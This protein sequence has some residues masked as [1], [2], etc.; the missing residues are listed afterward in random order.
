MEKDTRLGNPNR[1]MVRE[2][3]TVEAIIGLYCE[4]HHAPQGKLCPECQ[5]LLQYAQE[6]LDNCPFQ[7]HKTTCEK[8]PVHCYK[9]AQREKAR[10]IMRFA[11]PRMT[12]RHPVYSLFHLLDKFR[13]VEHPMEMRRRAKASRPGK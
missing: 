8:C 12:W 7:E 10:Q 5:E 11:G 4:K 9:P 3:K 13:K 1:R 6:R 2:Q